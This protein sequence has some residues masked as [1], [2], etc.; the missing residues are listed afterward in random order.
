MRSGYAPNARWQAHGGG[1]WRKRIAT[2]RPSMIVTRVNAGMARAKA[3]GTKS[4]K[5]IGRPRIASK[6]V[7]QIKSHLA[8]GDGVNKTARLCGVGNGTVARVK[9]ATSS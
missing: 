2:H 5:A 3:H 4:G 9:A 1:T 8:A 7:P 6:V